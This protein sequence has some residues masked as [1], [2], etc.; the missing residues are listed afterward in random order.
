[1]FLKKTSASDAVQIHGEIEH[2][3]SVESEAFIAADATVEASAT[4][5]IEPTAEVTSKSPKDLW[6][7]TGIRLQATV[8]AQKQLRLKALSAIRPFTAEEQERYQTLFRMQF[9]W[10]SGEP[11]LME[12]V[13]AWASATPGVIM[14]DSG[15]ALV[16]EVQS[17]AP[18]E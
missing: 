18:S 5:T 9:F 10:Q 2:L 8:R 7:I 17:N 3:A 6:R 1:V 16:D 11:I 4:V 14:T 15:L 12:E 13:T